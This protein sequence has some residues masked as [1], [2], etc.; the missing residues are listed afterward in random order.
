[1]AKHVK[2]F[3]I[4]A[5]AVVI[6]MYFFLTPRGA[7]SLQLLP[8]NPVYA[9]SF[10]ADV[11]EGVGPDKGCPVYLLENP[12]QMELTGNRLDRWTVHRLGPLCWA[13]YGYA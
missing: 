1:M 11:S 6:A 7:V 4:P 13:T 12:P 10:Q 5:L 9:L 3:L 2:Q 8:H